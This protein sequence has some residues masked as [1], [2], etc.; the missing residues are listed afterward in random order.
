M[1]KSLLPLA[2]VALVLG[3]TASA[4]PQVA[5]PPRAV[6][7]VPT[8]GDGPP[9][10][11]DGDEPPGPPGAKGRP[12]GPGGPGGGPQESPRHARLKQLNFDRRPSAVLKEWAP[13]P[14]DDKPTP[15]KDPKVEALDKEIAE[16]QKN[17][18][19]GKW[20]EVKS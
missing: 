3:V 2:F 18:T 5:P 9:D 4:Y 10:G 14:K 11:P 16:F 12:G 6:Q 19:L 13:K 17:V 8:P 20:T 1:R 15:P 7:P